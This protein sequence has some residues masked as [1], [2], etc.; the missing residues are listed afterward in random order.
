MIYIPQNP[1]THKTWR[2][3]YR[4]FWE[5]RNQIKYQRERGPGYYFRWTGNITGVYLP[6]PWVIWQTRTIFHG[7]IIVAISIRIRSRD[8]TTG[9]GLADK[10]IAVQIHMGSKIVS[11]P[12]RPY[13]LWGA[14]NLSNGYQPGAFHP[15]GGGSGRGVADHSLPTI[16]KVEKTCI[17]TSTPP[18]VLMSQYVISSIPGATRFSE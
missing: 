15:P 5:D 10:K 4:L 18:Y 9:Y 17:Y 12:R 1:N 11:S 2:K 14:T 8:S 3:K 13:R 16:A 7:L 6:L